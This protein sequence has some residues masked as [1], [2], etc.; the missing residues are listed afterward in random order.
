MF[1][2][3]G[4]IQRIKILFNKRENALIQFGNSQHASTALRMLNGTVLFGKAMTLATSTKNS[5]KMPAA[6][7]EEGSGAFNKDFSNSEFHRFKVA[8]S[9]NYQNICPP[10]S[11]LHVSNI[12]TPDENKIRELFSQFGHVS[13][14]KFFQ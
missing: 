11:T 10:S 1:S 5:I 14:F 2:C 3:Y 8:G 12:P 6:G 7:S 4:D 9:K 13:G